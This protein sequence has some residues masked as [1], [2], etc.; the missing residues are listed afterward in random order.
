MSGADRYLRRYVRIIDSDDAEWSGKLVKVTFGNPNGTFQLAPD[1]TTKNQIQPKESQFRLYAPD[2]FL[3]RYPQAR[4]L[5]GSHAMGAIPVGSVVDF[6]EADP[7]IG[8]TS[9]HLSIDGPCRIVGRPLTHPLG[10]T[11]TVNNHILVKAMP[12]DLVEFEHMVF[13]GLAPSGAWEMDCAAGQIVFRNCTF[14]NLMR[15]VMIGFGVTDKIRVTFENCT[16]T[17]IAEFGVMVRDGCTHMHKCTFDHCGVGVAVKQNGY[18]DIVTSTFE[19]CVGGV[20]V[21]SGG[22][23]VVNN[24]EFNHMKDF[25]VHVSGGSFLHSCS[26]TAVGCP[27]SALVVESSSTHTRLKAWLFKE[28]KI[29]LRLGNGQINA[30]LIGNAFRD[31]KV[32]TFITPDAGGEVAIFGHDKGSTVN[33]SGEKFRIYLDNMFRDE[34]PPNAQVDALHATRAMLAEN[35]IKYGYPLTALT[36]KVLAEAGILD[37]VCAKCKA[38][39]PKDDIYKKCARCNEARYCSRACQESH[40]PAHYVSC[41]IREQRADRMA[42]RGFVECDHCRTI[43]SYMTGVPHNAC[44][45]CLGVFFCGKECQKAGWLLH[46]K[47]C[48]TYVNPK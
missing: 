31:C 7:S 19:H 12:Y 11:Q 37:I 9:P 28:C 43:E 21:P 18:V 32:G 40:W 26:C 1:L 23:A 48:K 46:K 45:R 29:G 6:S 27:G 3:A 15:G 47:N 34:E 30:I 17:N 16:F 25:G 4:R 42:T 38:V 33:L 22:E 2:L 36:R 44:G 13:D 8:K 41:R 39:A 14:V 10:R 5:K 24:T 20:A 35:D